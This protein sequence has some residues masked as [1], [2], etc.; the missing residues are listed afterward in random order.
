MSDVATAPTPICKCGATEKLASDS[1]RCSKGHTLIDTPLR[2]EHGVRKFEASGKVP[3]PLRQTIDEFRESVITDRG[4]A[5]ELSTLEASYVRRLSE[6]ET[7]VRLLT[8][9]IATRGLLTPSGR[10]R[11]VLQRWN[12]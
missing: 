7:I 9:D 5:A 3:E 2:L 10:V 11:G 6:T 1:F 12:E 4:G 8:A